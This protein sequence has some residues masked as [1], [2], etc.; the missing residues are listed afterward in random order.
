MP[1]EFNKDKPNS[2]K[3]KVIGGNHQR[4]AIQVMQTEDPDNIKYKYTRSFPNRLVKPE[5]YLRTGGFLMKYKATFY[6]F[7]SSYG[8]FCRDTTERRIPSSAKT[9]QLDTR[10]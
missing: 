2:H 4:V 10:C 9:D 1:K 8:S 7:T 6:L 3:L 5:L